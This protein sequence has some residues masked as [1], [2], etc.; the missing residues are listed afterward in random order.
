MEDGAERAIDVADV[1]GIENSGW[2]VVDFRNG[3]D[4]LPIRGWLRLGSRFV[5]HC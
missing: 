5:G 2:G 1:S 3:H 4:H